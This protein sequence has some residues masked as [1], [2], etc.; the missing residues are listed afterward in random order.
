MDQKGVLNNWVNFMA[1]KIPQG[2][3]KIKSV[4]ISPEMLNRLQAEVQPG[5]DTSRYFG[6][7]FEVVENLP[8]GVEY[9]Y[10]ESI[11]GRGVVEDLIPYVKKTE[12]R[13]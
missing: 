4:R 11:W 13:G 12:K 10:E 2:P 6:L 3:P 8:L 7:P 1:N 5:D 9:V